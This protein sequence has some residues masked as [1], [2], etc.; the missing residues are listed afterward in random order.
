MKKTINA[1]ICIVL[2]ICLCM[3]LCGCSAKKEELVKDYE[4]KG[5]AV[6]DFSSVKLSELTNY[7]D[8]YLNDIDAVEW[9]VFGQ[10]E[11]SSDWVEIIGFTSS[12]NANRYSK[13]DR[14]KDLEKSYTD[15]V[16][17][18]KQVSVHKTVKGSVFILEVVYEK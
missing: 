7:C 16:T 8:V 17:D 18:E 13:T 10:K 9:A 3:A 15:P 5:Y 12:K 1:F 14:Y 2:I 6:A 4:D 11:G